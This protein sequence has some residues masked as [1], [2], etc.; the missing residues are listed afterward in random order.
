MSIKTEIENNFHVLKCKYCDQSCYEYVGVRPIN[1]D[2][3]IMATDLAPIDET[4]PLAV[5][6]EKLSCPFCRS[7]LIQGV[8]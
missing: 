1:P 4:I 7:I 5:A 8:G 6:G 3:P 2:L